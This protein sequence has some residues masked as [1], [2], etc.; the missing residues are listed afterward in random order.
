M[1]SGHRRGRVVGGL[2]R[3]LGEQRQQLR[4]GCAVPERRGARRQRGNTH[5]H[6]HTHAHTV[7]YTHT[8]KQTEN[9]ER[10]V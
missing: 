7:T 6:P 10:D 5:S 9:R 1:F 3:G 2:L 4:A 8:H